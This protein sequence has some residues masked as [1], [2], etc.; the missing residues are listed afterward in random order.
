MVPRHW[1]VTC[2]LF[3]LVKIECKTT[4]GVGKG[5]CCEIKNWLHFGK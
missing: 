5:K 4:A 2:L 3:N 1:F